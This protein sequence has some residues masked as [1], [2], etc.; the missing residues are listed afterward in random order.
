M[1]WGWGKAGNTAQ[2]SPA[3]AGAW[4]SLAIKE[5]IFSV[6]KE[7]YLAISVWGDGSALIDQGP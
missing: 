6:Q 3:G 2:L 1:G 5:N 4:L 7:V